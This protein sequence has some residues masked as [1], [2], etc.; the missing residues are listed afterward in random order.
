MF[1]NLIFCWD[2]GS[3]PPN[4][5]HQVCMFPPCQK[6]ILHKNNLALEAANDLIVKTGN[7]A[8][9]W[10]TSNW[11]EIPIFPSQFKFWLTSDCWFAIFLTYSMAGWKKG[12]LLDQLLKTSKYVLF[13]LSSLCTI[14]SRRAYA[15]DKGHVRKRH[16]RACP[17]FWIWGS[18]SPHQEWNINLSILSSEKLFTCYNHFIQAFVHSGF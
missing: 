12:Q 18:I 2:P 4:T 8:Q 16:T 17:W 5:M 3:V 1:S 15:S 11:G 13:T 10:L 7:K 9:L 14:I 6:Y